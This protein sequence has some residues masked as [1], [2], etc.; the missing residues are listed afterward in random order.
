MVNVIGLE[1]K[2]EKVHEHYISIWSQWTDFREDFKL[3]TMV[4]KSTYRII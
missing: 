2:I 3:E 1:K 4:F